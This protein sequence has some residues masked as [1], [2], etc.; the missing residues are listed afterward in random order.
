MGDFSRDEIEA[1]FA[2]YRRRA[3]EQDDWA[4][5]ADLFTEDALYVEHVMGTFQGRQ[6][7]SDWIVATMAEYSAM[8]T[9]IEWHQIEG[10]K[11]AFYVWNNLPAPA[12][13][14]Q[15]FQF[16]NTSILTYAGDGKFS[17]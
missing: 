7:I 17:E 4:A 13:T 10:D 2:E 6:A 3:E 14:T 1:A 11:V 8:S 12:G 16:P 5:W 15:A 9:W